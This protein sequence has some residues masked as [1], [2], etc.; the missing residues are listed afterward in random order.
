MP[1]LVGFILEFEAFLGRLVVVIRALTYLLTP[2]LIILTPRPRGPVTGFRP[3]CI[4]SS[5]WRQKPPNPLNP[6]HR[7]LQPL[8]PLPLLPIPPL[9]N[10]N[11][12]LQLRPRLPFRSHHLISLLEQLRAQLLQLATRF[13]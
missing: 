7:T 9:Q 2:L 11:P 10:L 6:L 1:L 8:Q 3:S 12:L 5:P 13:I 4:C